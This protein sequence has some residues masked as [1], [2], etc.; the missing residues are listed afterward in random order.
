MRGC[1]PGQDL[2]ARSA[3]RRGLEDLA[4]EVHAAVADERAGLH[5][6]VELVEHVLGVVGSHVA[7]VRTISA[8]S[9]STS[10]SRICARTLAARLAHL[11]EED[12]SSLQ[13]STGVA[14][15]A[16]PSA[17]SIARGRRSAIRDLRSASQPRSSCGDLVGLRLDHFADL[18]RGRWARRSAAGS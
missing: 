1:E 2:L 11:H 4:G 3:P 8:V 5:D 18:A 9:S 12:G 14:F 13:R 15:C 10:P 16:G 17:C 7:A 6:A